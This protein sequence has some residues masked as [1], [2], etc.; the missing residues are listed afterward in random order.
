MK[1]RGVGDANDQAIFGEDLGH[2][3]SPRLGAG[4]MHQL[5]T[6][7]L[8]LLPCRFTASGP[9]TSNSIDAWGTILSAGHSGVP[10]HATAACGSGHTPK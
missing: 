2:R 4:G 1:G 6:R 7:S 5:E 9:S 8:K 3:R 10:K